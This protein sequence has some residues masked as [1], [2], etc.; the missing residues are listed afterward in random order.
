MFYWFFD[1]LAIISKLKL[2]SLDPAYQ[3]KLAAMAWFMGAFLGILKDLVD[4]NEL[5][6]KKSKSKI[7]GSDSNNTGANLEVDKKILQTYLNIIGKVG[8]LFPSGNGSGI[9]LMLFGKNFSESSVG[10]GGFISAV[11]SCYNIWYS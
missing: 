2:I 4:L 8:D 6:I 9:A 11:I 1:N 3:A 5:L 7:D 10:Y